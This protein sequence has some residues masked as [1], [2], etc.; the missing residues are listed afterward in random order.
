MLNY[1]FLLYFKPT[2]DD[3]RTSQSNEYIILVIEILGTEVEV[4]R[5]KDIIGTKIIIDVIVE[6]KVS[7]DLIFDNLYCA[8]NVL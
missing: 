8:V 2:L 3:T 6:I 4:D 5:E 7:R 1:F